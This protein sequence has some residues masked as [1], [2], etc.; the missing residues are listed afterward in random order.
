MSSLR[1]W[2]LSRGKP[3][4]VHKAGAPKTILLA[5]SVDPWGPP[6]RSVRSGPVVVDVWGLDRRVALVE[7]HYFVRSSWYPDRIEAY[8]DVESG[9]AG[10]P[11]EG[12]TGSVQAVAIESSDGG[13]VVELGI[14]PSALWLNGGG[15][16]DGT[17]LVSGMAGVRFKFY[18]EAV[19][20]GAIYNT[21]S[22]DLV[23]RIEVKPDGR[24][25]CGDVIEEIVSGLR[26]TGPGDP[27][28]NLLAPY[29]G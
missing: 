14:L 13:P 22:W 5:A 10:T 4:P 15:L 7:R 2:D 28:L 24:L 27:P 8:A 29:A 16:V 20:G 18:V 3:E 6:V 1:A 21:T 25:G 23:M 11:G 12:L 26:L 19:G 9:L 17:E